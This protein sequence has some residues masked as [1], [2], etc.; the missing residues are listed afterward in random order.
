[1]GGRVTLCLALASSVSSLAAEKKDAAFLFD[2]VAYWHR[3]SQKGQNEFTPQGQEDL[4]RWTEMVTINLHEE[5][6]DG[7]QL[8]VLANQVLGRY[9]ATGKIL[10]TDSK[11]RTKEH[12]AEHF[13]AAVLV[14]PTFL[15]AAFARF[16]LID[17]RGIVVVH[18]HRVY[19]TK[20]GNEMAAWLDKHG[21]DAEKSLMAWTQLPSLDRLKALPQAPR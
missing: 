15:E 4:D 9:Q 13:A 7:E 18:S 2:D 21:A 10:K 12:P 8:A 20:A 5:V 14:D 11:P 1:M 6:R 16:V 17:G 3:W 19:G